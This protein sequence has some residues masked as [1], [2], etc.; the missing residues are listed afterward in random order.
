M[1]IKVLTP[2]AAPYISPDHYCMNLMTE[3]VIH[4][5][6]LLSTKLLQTSCENA[7]LNETMFHNK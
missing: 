5:S 7:N 6:V 3:R 4:C 1:Q 2:E